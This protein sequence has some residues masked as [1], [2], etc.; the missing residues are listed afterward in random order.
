MKNLYKMLVL[1]ILI[2]II[3]GC[4]NKEK[5][6]KDIQETLDNMGETSS[7]SL[8]EDLEEDSFVE[9]EVIPS[10]G[11]TLNVASYPIKTLDP[12]QNDRQSITQ[13]LELIYEPLFKLDNSLK[14]VPNIVENYSFDDNRKKLTINL[15]EG[16]RFHNNNMLTTKDIK[17]TI[18]TI[19]DLE[20]S[21]YKKQVIPI[22]RISIID[23]YQIVIYYDK[24]YSF[25]LSDL[26]FPIVSSEYRASK[27]Y[28][29]LKP[30]GTGPYRYKEYQEM[31]F[32]DLTAYDDWHNGE[33]MIASIH[34]VIIENGQ[35]FEMLFDQHLID[36]MSSNKFDWL[37]YSDDEDQ[38]IESYT[39]SY[40]DFIGFNFDNELLAEKTV[41][42]AMA[43]AIDRETLSLDYFIN[44]IKLV[45]SPVN[46]SAWFATNNDLA[47]EYDLKKAKSLLPGALVDN[48]GDGF[49]DE[50]DLIQSDKYNKIILDMI[51]NNTQPLRVMTA[52]YIADSFKELGIYV[53][54]QIVEPEI[55]YTRIE[56]GDYDLVYGG[57]KV[58]QV[59]DYVALFDT[60]GEQNFTNYSSAPMDAVLNM[61]VEADSEEEVV[62][63]VEEFSEIMIDEVPYISLYFLEGAIIS[64]NNVYGEFDSTTENIY[65]SIENIYVEH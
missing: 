5:N 59:P 42:Q 17:Y 1:V 28:D 32:L 7:E 22:K 12:L 18:N 48:D 65:H 52:D 35:S 11:G 46:P 38:H 45:D 58:S 61:I 44:H 6:D 57:W 26:T 3:G 9:D 29:P 53:E 56:S 13:L 21:S 4:Y 34:N 33:V 10:F 16:I 40:Y 63:Y 60:F 47:Y 55:Y 49:I 23:D 43:S 39:S 25:A 37:K 51:V 31:Q 64:H 2:L 14:P 8:E 30:V 20:I 27:K 15:K 24:S 19:K 62:S 36:V 50:V 54:V 41:R